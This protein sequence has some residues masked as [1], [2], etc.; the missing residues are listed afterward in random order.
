MRRTMKKPVT[1][2]MI[3]A[4]LAAIIPG[5]DRQTDRRT[6]QAID[7]DYQR[8]RDVREAERAEHIRIVGAELFEAWLE[9]QKAKCLRQA[10]DA[11]DADRPEM[12]WEQCADALLQR[13]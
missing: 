7:A 2:D 11:F 8:R 6:I 9:S 12:T 1:A 3:P 10:A 13:E 5:R 4:K